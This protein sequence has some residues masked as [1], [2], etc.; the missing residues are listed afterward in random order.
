MIILLLLALALPA[1][2]APPPCPDG[3]FTLADDAARALGLASV[4]GVEQVLLGDGRVTVVGDRTSIAHVGAALVRAGTVP[5]D[6]TVDV[7]NRSIR[8]E[9]S[10]EELA[11]RKA[12]LKPEPPRY[13]RGYGWMFSRHIGQADEGCDFDFLRTDFGAPV[14]EPVIF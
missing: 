9:V 12:A 11:R 8:M 3:R 7:P 10:D 4:E 5:A 6:L 1:F 2:A 13:E 14:S